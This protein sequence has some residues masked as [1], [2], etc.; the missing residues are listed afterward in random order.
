MVD[1]TVMRMEDGP[2]RAREEI[3]TAWP[4]VCPVAWACKT[5][6]NL[7]RRNA[8]FLVRL[9]SFHGTI[10]QSLLPVARQEGKR[11]VRHQGSSLPLFAVTR[12]EGWPRGLL[13][14]SFC[15]PILSCRTGAL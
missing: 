8:R 1:V 3:S 6:K 5:A 15:R 7:E 11:N 13:F 2:H 12:V 14:R 9:L 10:S 4:F